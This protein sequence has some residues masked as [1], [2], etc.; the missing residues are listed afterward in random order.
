MVLPNGKPHHHHSKV[1]AKK[2]REVESSQGMP[3]AIS[4]MIVSEKGLECG[5][6][7]GQE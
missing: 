2:A 1:M 6:R 5:D 4:P 7:R 3:K